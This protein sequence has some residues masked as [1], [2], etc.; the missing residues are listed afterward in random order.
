MS[1]GKFIIESDFVDS[2]V[3][4][5][6]AS[7][8]ENHYNYRNEKNFRIFAQCVHMNP[9]S[10]KYSNCNGARNYVNDYL[11]KN[12]EVSELNSQ[13][14]TNC[15]QNVLNAQRLFYTLNT[16]E[17]SAAQETDIN[18]S[19]NLSVGDLHRCIKKSGINIL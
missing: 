4:Y 5:Q 3:N 7:Y 10:L 19:Y 15:P 6:I 16:Q 12:P 2:F 9:L 18:R 14:V 8:A 1:D 13:I 11:E 17:M